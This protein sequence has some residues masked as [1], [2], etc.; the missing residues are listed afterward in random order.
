V[1]SAQRT[2][3]GQAVEVPMFEALSQF[4]MG[5]HLGGHSFEPPLG[6]TG[7]ARLLAPHRK[8]YATADG[9]LSVLIYNDKHWQAFFDVIGRPELRASLARDLGDRLTTV[10]IDCGH[11]HYWDAFDDTAAALR[12][13][14]T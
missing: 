1:L 8:P 3:K 13:F 2:G 7:Y 10:E 6:P 5:D 12:G 9:H 4:V 14:L 11:M